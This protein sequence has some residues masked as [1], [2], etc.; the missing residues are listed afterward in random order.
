[1]AGHVMLLG[2][3]W[4]HVSLCMRRALARSTPVTVPH[5]AVAACTHPRP[6]C[7][8][9]RATPVCVPGPRDTHSARWCL[10]QGT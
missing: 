1:M 2:P 10:D 6:K 9:L 5:A 4:A 8:T 3:S 7:C